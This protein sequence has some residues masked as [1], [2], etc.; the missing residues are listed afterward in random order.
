MLRLL[1]PN[2]LLAEHPHDDLIVVGSRVNEATL[3]LKAEIDGVYNSR[4]IARSDR[5]RYAPQIELQKRKRKNAIEHSTCRPASLSIRGDMRA[6]RSIHEH[7]IKRH[8]AQ[9]VAIINRERLRVARPDD[10]AYALSRPSDLV[11]ARNDESFH[12][13][14][15]K[16][17]HGAPL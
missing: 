16:R 12:P 7:V 5:C 11:I 3:E 8:C 15:D 13:C 1:D 10:A 4:L 9:F 2:A 17:F 6:T 14:D